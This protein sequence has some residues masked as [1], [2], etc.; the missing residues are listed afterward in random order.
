MKTFTGGC[1]F[2]IVAGLVFVAILASPVLLPVVNTAEDNAA[3]RR[4]KQ[5]AE[6]ARAQAE[7]EAAQAQ[8][9]LLRM[10]TQAGVSAIEADRYRA[11][12]EMWLAETLSR[13]LLMISI[14]V[15]IAFIAL[16]VIYWKNPEAGQRIIDRLER[17]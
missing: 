5:S 11:H 3:A 6:Q 1:L 4:A 14:P 8:A 2:W 17:K 10:Y 7:L 16:A 12:P 13:A 9:D 15:C